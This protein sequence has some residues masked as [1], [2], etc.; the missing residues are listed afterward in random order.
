[1]LCVCVC[2]CMYV[3]SVFHFRG[4]EYEPTDSSSW[5]LVD[6]VAFDA[7]I[8]SS[9]SFK[10]KLNLNIYIRSLFSNIKFFYTK[11]ER[12]RERDWFYNIC[13]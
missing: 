8:S 1:M 3:L 5:T 6:S 10:S 2:V 7:S 13:V 9:D 11:R 12:E 4:I